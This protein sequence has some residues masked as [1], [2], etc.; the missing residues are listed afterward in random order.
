MSLIILGWA[1]LPKCATDATFERRLRWGPG[2]AQITKEGQGRA[3]KGRF[4]KNQHLRL[5][6][7]LHLIKAFNISGFD[8]VEFPLESPSIFGPNPEN[9]QKLLT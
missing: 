3:G 7:T 2:L 4:E 9:P 1:A 8:S 6:K 5:A